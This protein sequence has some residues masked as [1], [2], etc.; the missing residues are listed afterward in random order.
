MDFNEKSLYLCK[1]NYKLK[2]PTPSSLQTVFN[3]GTSIGLLAQ[4]LY[5]NGADASP[6]NHFKIF[7]SVRKSDLI[8]QG[9]NVIYEATF[10][11]ND[12]LAALDIWSKI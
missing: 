10:I 5:P 7:E 9:K 11:F 6:K 8:S 3:Q 1:H 4:E 12:V 2:D